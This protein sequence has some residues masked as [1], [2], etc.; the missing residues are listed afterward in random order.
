VTLAQF[1]PSLL[2]A[3]I[4]TAPKRDGFQCRYLFCGGEA[5]SAE[6]AREAA[7]FTSEAVINLYGPAEATIDSTAG[8][9]NASSSANGAV[10]IGGPI[11][12]ASVYVLDKYLEPVPV[13]ISG[14]LYIAGAGVARGYLSRAELT[15]E[16]F[17]ANP[18]ADEQGSRMY[19]TGD[20]GRWLRDGTIEFLGRNDRQVKLRGYRIELGE[21]EARLREHDGIREAVVVLENTAGNK[22]LVAYFATAQSVTDLRSEVLRTHM[23]ARLP[24][25]MVPA[26]YVRMESLP[27][28]SN[29]KLDR[30]ALPIPEEDSYSLRRYEAPADEMEILLAAIWTEVLK[31]ERVGRHDNFFDLGGHSLLVVQVITRLRRAVSVEVSIAD[32]FANPVLAD[33]ARSLKR[34]STEVQCMTATGPNGHKIVSY[35]GGNTW[36]DQQTSESV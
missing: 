8:K 6:L 9:W 15:A 18:F 10:S 3:V 20:V 35:D 22:Q 4:D 27:R 26:A 12:N 24:V 36:F 28:T 30:N 5:L 29:G 31:L 21:I 19:R 33:F 13:G 17:V 34:A 11:A 32:L 23:A 16:R 25:Y 7:L 1:V 2:Q 14:E